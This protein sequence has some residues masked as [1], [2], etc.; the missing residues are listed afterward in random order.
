MLNGVP[1][2]A[3]RIAVAAF[4]VQWFFDEPL[5]NPGSLVTSTKG[6][7]Q[8]SH[9]G[10]TFRNAPQYSIVLR[11]GGTATTVTSNS[12]YDPQ[13]IDLKQDRAAFVQVNDRIGPGNRFE[14]NT[15][16]FSMWVKLID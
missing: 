7:L 1:L 5:D 14:N 16:T 3:N 12:R 13:F 4:D 9:A 2:N 8:E 10:F 15:G 6:N 11:Q